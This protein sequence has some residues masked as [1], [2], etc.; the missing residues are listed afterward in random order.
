[1]KRTHKKRRHGNQ[2]HKMEDKKKMKTIDPQNI[3]K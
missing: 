2:Q 3:T 1:M